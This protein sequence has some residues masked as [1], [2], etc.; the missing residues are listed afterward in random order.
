MTRNL[1]YVRWLAALAVIVS[2][3]VHLKLWTDGMKDFDVLGPAFLANAIGGLVIAVLLV[4]WHHWVP[5]F[6]ALGFGLSTLGGFILATLPNGLFDAHEH[7]EGGYVWAAAIAEVIAIVTGA[8]L[9]LEDN[10]L[11]SRGQ[12]EHRSTVGG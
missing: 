1:N 2:A 3:Y 5:A 12:L 4:T 10:P 9:L 8:L 7:W 11:R 6:L